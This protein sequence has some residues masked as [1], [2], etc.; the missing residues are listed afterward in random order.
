[1]SS[2]GFKASKIKKVVNCIFIQAE[3][4][5]SPLRNT[6][7]QNLMECYNSSVK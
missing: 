5:S 6:W 1:M 2:R 3:K 4:R 7:K